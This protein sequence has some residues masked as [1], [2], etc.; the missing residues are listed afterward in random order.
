VRISP[1]ANS[2]IWEGTEV[3]VNKAACLLYVLRLSLGVR[4][5]FYCSFII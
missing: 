2:N 5:H 4:R 1:P 3:W